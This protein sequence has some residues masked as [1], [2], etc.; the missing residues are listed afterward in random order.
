MSP[1]ARIVPLLCKAQHRFPRVY[2]F[3]QQ[4]RQATAPE[5]GITNP[6]RRPDAEGLVCPDAEA[7]GLSGRLLSRA[8]PVSPLS[9]GK[10]CW[11]VG[12][13]LFGGG[14]PLGHPAE[15]RH[16]RAHTQNMTSP[17]L[18]PSVS[19]TGQI[20]QSMSSGQSSR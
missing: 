4:I 18:D 20:F 7:H 12:R 1:G 9:W 16:Q 8:L 15:V 6:K 10:S 13:F 3:A 14:K 19:K 2:V 11:F 17:L 5:N